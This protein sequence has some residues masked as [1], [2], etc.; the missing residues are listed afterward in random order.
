MFRAG[1]RR[2]SRACYLLWVEWGQPR[3]WQSCGGGSMVAESNA[4]LIKVGNSREIQVKQE[5][6]LGRQAECDVLLT[7]GHT[8][9]RHAKLVQAEDGYWLED[10]GSSNGTFIN[11]NRISGRVKVAS[12]D[13]LR[14]DVEEF[15]FRIPGQAAPAALDES[16]TVYRAPESAAVVA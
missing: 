5:T 9:R 7:E 12:G 15:D 2:N 16:K 10:L 4:I 8:S 1:C 13:R 6:V 11:G 3:W 14:F